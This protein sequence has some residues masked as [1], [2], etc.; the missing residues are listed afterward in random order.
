MRA[1][2]CVSGFCCTNAEGGLHGALG[3][4]REYDESSTVRSAVDFQVLEV[5]RLGVN[6]GNDSRNRLQHRVWNFYG[7]NPVE[8]SVAPDQ[9]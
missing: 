9:R 8:I 1:G 4:D 3:S 5:H 6:F 7:T 2:R